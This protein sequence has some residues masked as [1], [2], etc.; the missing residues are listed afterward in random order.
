MIGDAGI[1][2]YKGGLGSD[3]Y[4]FR[5]DLAGIIQDLSG[6]SSVVPGVPNSVEL[7]HAIVVDF[8]PTE[9]IIGFQRLRALLRTLWLGMSSSKS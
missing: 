2:I 9:D 5:T 4:V 6:I 7:P 8:N 3:V 1:G